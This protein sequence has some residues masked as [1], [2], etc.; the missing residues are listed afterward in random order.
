MY[1]QKHLE[2]HLVH[3]LTHDHF[4]VNYKH[5]GKLCTRNF[6]SEKMDLRNEEL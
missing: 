1:L 2:F 6:L 4:L 5:N 3:P